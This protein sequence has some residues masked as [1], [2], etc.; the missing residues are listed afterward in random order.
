MATDV[1][2]LSLDISVN[3][4]ERA[5]SAM[6]A[7]RSG[8]VKLTRATDEQIAAQ[9]RLTS[10]FN[11]Q[12]APAVGR[13]R[14]SL[15][16]L[17]QSF[18]L[19]KG[20]TQQAGFQIQDFT[21]QIAAGQSAT[22]AFGQQA[23]QLAG[24]LGPGGAVL[25]AFI[26]IGAALTGVVMTAFSETE[27]STESLRKRILDLRDSVDELT[28]AQIRQ[29]K[30]EFFAENRARLKQI[31]EFR[32]RIRDLRSELEAF[33]NAGADGTQVTAGLTDPDKARAE[34][35]RLTAEIDTLFQTGNQAAEEL[36]ELINGTDEAGEAA[37]KAAE[38]VREMVEAAEQQAAT[39]GLSARATA[40]YE[41]ALAG[42]NAEQIM[43]ID[44]AYRRV[45]AHKQEVAQQK[46]L[47]EQYKVTAANDPLLQRVS[48]QDRGGEIIEGIR[49]EAEAVRNGLDQEFAIRLAHKERVMAL[50]DG[51]RMGVI[52]NAEE[53]NRLEVESLRQRNEQLRQIE[54]QKYDILGSGQ[55]A[56]LSATENMFGNLA[57][58]AEKGGKD[59]FSTWKAMASAQAAVSTA[60]AVANALTAAP[61]P[62]NFALAASVGALGAVQ[63][64][65]IQA[66]EYQGSY[67]GG[68]YT[69]QGSRSGGVD[70]KGGF[71][72]ILHPN[73]T[74]IDH[75]IGQRSNS[76]T[77]NANVT[78][79][80]QLSDNA[81]REAKQQIL[82]SAPMIQQMAKQAV[83]QA[84]NQG[85][86][87]SRAV[88]RRS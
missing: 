50:D 80:F 88:G 4:A 19:Q 23:S 34:I 12:S 54:M 58:I 78:Q 7:V 65:Q 20:A 9:T 43:A 70:G 67:L 2:R 47:Q 52:E 63:I 38:K 75:E 41:A 69:G 66:Q 72:A 13:F 85:G 57:S 10:A 82:E 60:L 59:Q 87:M 56:F 48:A 49:Q 25:G 62:A 33:A 1:A 18:K 15:S 51:L 79:V 24:I 32:S 74:V 5:Q 21:T 14:R 11:R 8:S 3:G 6:E 83:L 40:T 28:D 44:A 71:P 45:E 53:R 81:R 46:A 29:V 64:A 61:P 30:V 84:I 68:G 27:E 39:I 55:E 76:N 16:G 73:E 86:P 17:R 22:V 31:N 36:D 37:E 26:A 35:N 77:N 42:A